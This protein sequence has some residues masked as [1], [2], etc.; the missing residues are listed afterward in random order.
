ME[1]EEADALEVAAQAHEEGEAQ[2]PEEVG[3]W[4]SG[5]A[6]RDAPGRRA[7]IDMTAELAII[8]TMFSH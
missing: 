7:S 5:T 2:T 1:E 8:I 6:H 4:I 3:S